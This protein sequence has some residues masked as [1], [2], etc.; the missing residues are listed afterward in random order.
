ME[1]RRNITSAPQGSALLMV[2]AIVG[3]LSLI[4]SATLIVVSGGFKKA[5]QRSAGFEAHL[6]AQRGVSLGTHPQVLRDDDLLHYQAE[7]GV[8]GYDVVI[9]SEGARLNING[10][11]QRRDKSFLRVLFEEWGLDVGDASMLADAMID[12]ADFD[13]I[14]EIEG[15]EAEYYENQGYEDR[16]YNKPFQRLEDLLLVRDFD[17]VAELQPDWREW[18]TIWGDTE[19]DIHEVAP[20]LLSV[21]AEVDVDLAE[22]FHRDVIG[23]DEILGTS[24]DLAFSSL[25]GALDRLGVTDEVE[26]RSRVVRRFRLRSGVRRV[27]SRGR[28]GDTTKKITVIVRNSV[29]NRPSVLRYRDALVVEKINQLSKEG[30]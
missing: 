2:L 26:E 20:R 8:D 25:T 14:E 28:S 27:V 4:L 6:M 11:L 23:E 17:K 3:F 5:S 13:E 15:A 18:L 10:V 9:S 19:L 7:D 1:S 12:W 21:A 16:P 29:N 24:D 30:E 22:I